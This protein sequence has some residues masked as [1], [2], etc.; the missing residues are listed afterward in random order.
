MAIVIFELIKLDIHYNNYSF[1]VSKVYRRW[2]ITVGA[3]LDV[4][5]YD[6]CNVVFDY[7]KR[8]KL[9]GTLALFNIETV[10]TTGPLKKTFNKIKKIKIF[11]F[12]L[13]DNDANY[14]TVN[15]SSASHWVYPRRWCHRLLTQLYLRT[16]I[17]FSGFIPSNRFLTVNMYLLIT[18]ESF[19]W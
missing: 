16:A 6:R 19:L 9:L 3:S 2:L 17:H 8:R 7:F 1:V 14:I 18:I 10:S 15:K 13:N 5:K 4:L 12:T 11:I